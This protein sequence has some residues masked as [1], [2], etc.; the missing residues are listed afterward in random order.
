MS[1][2]QRK[3]DTYHWVIGAEGEDPMIALWG[4]RLFRVGIGGGLNKP[5]T[6]WVPDTKAEPLV[7]APDL[8]VS[9]MVQAVLTNA[10]LSRRL[11]EN[12]TRNNALLRHLSAKHSGEQP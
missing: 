12:M 8:S 9:D 10:D 7:Y 5:P 4:G 3:W 2:R 11:G 6:R 1:E